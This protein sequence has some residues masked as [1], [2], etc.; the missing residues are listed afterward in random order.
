VKIHEF[1]LWFEQNGRWSTTIPRE[2]GFYIYYDGDD[3]GYQHLDFALITY[4]SRPHVIHVKNT[5]LWD[6][7]YCLI[8]RKLTMDDFKIVENTDY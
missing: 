1:G 8:G 5:F 7:P 6:G 2:V 3:I 4:L